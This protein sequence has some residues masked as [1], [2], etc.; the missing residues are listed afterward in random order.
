MAAEL[1]CTDLRIFFGI[2]RESLTVWIVDRMVIGVKRHWSE[3]IKLQGEE[4]PIE[5]KEPA[6]CRRYEGL[7]AQQVLVGKRRLAR[8]DKCKRRG[9]ESPTLCGQRKGWGTRAVPDDN[10]KERAEKDAG[11]KPGAT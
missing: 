4:E 1:S 5:A 10:L 9:G 6:G 7:K 2:G 3:E 11:L 8:D